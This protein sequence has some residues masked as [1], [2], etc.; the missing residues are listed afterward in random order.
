VELESALYCNVKLEHS[1]LASFP[2]EAPW[3]TL[4]TRNTRIFQIDASRSLIEWI[5][6]EDFSLI[7]MNIFPRQPTVVRPSLR[8]GFVAK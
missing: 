7:D 3:G 8:P 2:F 6:A 5:R 4:F 1:Y